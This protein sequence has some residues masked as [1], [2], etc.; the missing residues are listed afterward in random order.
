MDLKWV[1]S[2]DKT[3]IFFFLFC[4]DS[5]MSDYSLA[6]KTLLLFRSNVVDSKKTNSERDY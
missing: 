5:G 1:F 3:K 6:F 4:S 2:T